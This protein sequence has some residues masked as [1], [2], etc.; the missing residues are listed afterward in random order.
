MALATCALGQL[1]ISPIADT[2]RSWV[3]DSWMRGTRWTRSRIVRAMEDGRVL[4]ARD[5]EGEDA[6]AYGWLC[7]VGDDVAH[8]FVKHDFWEMGVM[9]AMWGTAGEP[10]GLLGPATRVGKRVMERLRG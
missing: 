5:G 10:K 3:L 1:H 2:E 7:V 8:A 6:F 9:K 4:V